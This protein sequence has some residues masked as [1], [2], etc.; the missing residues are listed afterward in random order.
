MTLWESFTLLFW[1]GTASFLWW[2]SGKV[3][4]QTANPNL[5]SSKQKESVRRAKTLRNFG[6]LSAGLTIWLALGT[7]AMCAQ[8]IMTLPR[9]ATIVNV[10]FGDWSGDGDV[11]FTLPKDRPV[12]DWLDTIWK[13]NTPKKLAGAL[14]K[15]VMDENISSSNERI[16]RYSDAEQSVRYSEETGVYYFH[17]MLDK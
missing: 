13:L 8:R 15:P 11:S 9:E 14:E 10:E 3:W 5:D 1:G 17:I 7:T 12:S 2:Q 6:W 4:R 16:A